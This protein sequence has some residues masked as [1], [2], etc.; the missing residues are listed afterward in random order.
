[1]LGVVQQA[2]GNIQVRST[3]GV[4]TTITLY[5]PAVPIAAKQR[6]QLPSA[7]SLR[8]SGRILVVDDEEGVRTVLLG[9]LRRIGYEVDAVGDATTALA[10]L[11]MAPLR[12]DLV[13]SDILMPEMTGLELAGEIIE[14]KI[15]VE[16]VLMTGFADG[17]TVR[18]ATETFR[19][20]VLRK[21]FEV[22]QL[23]A[24]IEDALA[25]SFALRDG[26]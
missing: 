16:I 2:G 5:F 25:R 4:G 19:L 9:L 8:G 13:L 11:G 7:G 20:P 18:E 14:A 17:A 6:A 22:D 23:A 26:A 3:P 12:F 21:P 15:P 10:M 24:L 1:V